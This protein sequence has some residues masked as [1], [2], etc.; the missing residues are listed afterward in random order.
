MPSDY[1]MNVIVLQMPGTAFQVIGFRVCW[2]YQVPALTSSA[3]RDIAGASA[4]SRW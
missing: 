1:S 2:I 3:R 4:S